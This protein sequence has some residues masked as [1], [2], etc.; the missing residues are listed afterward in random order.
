MTQRICFWVMLVIFCASAAHGQNVL[1]LVQ[2]IPMADVEGRIDHFGIDLQGH[3]LFMS[4]LG[5][6][7]LEV[8]DLRANE[9]IHTVHG[10]REPQG[11]VYVAESRRIYVA[12]GGDGACRVFVGDTYKLLQVIRFASDA[13]NVRYDATA[14]QVLVGYGEGA[15][16][17]LDAG[18]RKLLGT[19][20]LDAHPESFQMETSGR[21][22]FVN[23]PSAGH[24]IAV[25]DR[26]RRKVIAQWKLEAAG[27]NFP[28]ALDEP[29][30]RL[31]VV[32]R[33][34]AEMIALD[35]ATGK[36]VARIPCVGDADDV[37]YDAGRRRIYISGGEGFISVIQQ[38]DPNHYVSIA[39]IETAP[40]ARTSFF[41]PQLDRLYLAVPRHASRPAELRVYEVQST[42]AL[43]ERPRIQRRSMIN[44]ETAGSLLDGEVGAW[45]R[46]RESLTALPLNYD[47]RP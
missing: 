46:W 27:D 17:I 24:G 20:R 35:T 21:R 29:D 8:F 40:G 6:N 14:H 25:V 16:G 1:R 47:Q 42:A 44:V 22:I 41:A 18:T 43:L 39:R 9:R 13:D 30:H 33:R 7:T 26:A 12:N 2:T 4:A 31:F 38:R 15:I 28:M 45:P 3:R 5:N 10:L 11:V 32:C 37:W 36:V 23:L 34:P 19:I